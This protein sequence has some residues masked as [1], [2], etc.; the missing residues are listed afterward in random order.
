MKNKVLPSLLAFEK[1]SWNKVLPIFW[2]KNMDLLHF[3][4]MEYA[5]VKNTAYNYNDIPDVLKINDNFK[6][7]VHLM[8][9]NPLKEI[10]KYN[11]KCVKTIYFHYN[12]YKLSFWTFLTICKIK[13]N[14]QNAGIAISPYDSFDQYKK[15]LKHVNNVLIM[16]VKPGKGG[17]QLIMSTINTLKKIY[18]YKINHNLNFKIE[19]DGGLNGTNIILIEKYVDYIVYGSYLKTI[20]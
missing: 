3:D 8:V 7:H 20:I 12:V 11:L 2:Y 4:V 5:Y 19:F 13:K 1:N 15:F 9:K 6:L 17:Q 18:D 14:N 16:G 10:N